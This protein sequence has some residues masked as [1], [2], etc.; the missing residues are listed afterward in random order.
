MKHVKILMLTV[1]VFLLAPL[2][3][4]AQSDMD[5][6][7]S[8]VINSSVILDMTQLAQ[9]QVITPGCEGKQLEEPCSL[10]TPGGEAML[11][12]CTRSPDGNGELIC[13]PSF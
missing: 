9:N 7:N 2:L 12:M 10:S 6:D 1:P 13:M 5:K 8:S 4:H 11:G 3:A